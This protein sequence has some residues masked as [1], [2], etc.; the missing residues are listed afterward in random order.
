MNTTTNAYCYALVKSNGCF[1]GVLMRAY[2]A[3]KLRKKRRW[4]KQSDFSHFSEPLQK[5]TQNNFVPQDVVE[6]FEILI[7]TT[8][9]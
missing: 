1:T 6:I 4:P 5:M 2:E 9:V 8:S 3:A 7:V